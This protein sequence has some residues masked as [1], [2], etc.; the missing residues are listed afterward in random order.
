MYASLWALDKGLLFIL[1]ILLV[2]WIADSFALITGRLIGKNKLAPN[3]SPKKTK[4]GV[5]GALI[6]NILMSIHLLICILW[7]FYSK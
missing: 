1:S 2:V 3:I 7:K 4:E 6:A 5:Y